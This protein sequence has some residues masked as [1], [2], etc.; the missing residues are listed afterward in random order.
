MSGH[1]AVADCPPSPADQAQGREWRDAIDSIPEHARDE[2][3]VA[4]LAAI[5][6]AD[7]TKDVGPL[8]QFLHGFE[9][10]LRMYQDEDYR[11]AIEI[12]PRTGDPGG[13]QD[14]AA[15]L[16]DLEQRYPVNS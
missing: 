1:R 5:A 10:T 15:L 9:I 7:R 6:T 13:G 14:V 2:V 12:A 16:A 3:R 4:F 11:R 8:L